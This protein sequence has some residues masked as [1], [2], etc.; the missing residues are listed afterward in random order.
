MTKLKNP[1]RPEAVEDLIQRLKKA[2]RRRRKGALPHRLWLALESL[3]DL[4]YVKKPFVRR[5]SKAKGMKARE[6]AELEP[7]KTREWL[8]SFMDHVSQELPAKTRGSRHLSALLVLLESEAEVYAEVCIALAAQRDPDDE[9]LRMFKPLRLR[10]SIDPGSR[11]ARHAEFDGENLDDAFENIQHLGWALRETLRELKIPFVH[12]GSELFR[13]NQV[14]SAHSAP[15]VAWCAVCWRTGHLAG[16]GMYFC[17]EHSSV[18]KRQQAYSL[19]HWRSA[20]QLAEDRSSYERVHFRA[21]NRLMPSGLAVGAVQDT[22]IRR[23]QLGQVAALESLEAYTIDVGE[24]VK[25]L[26]ETTEFLRDTTR[27]KPIDLSNARDV[28]T[29]LDPLAGRNRG[30]QELLHT[31][32]LKDQRILHER[33][34]YAE[35]W[36]RTAREKSMNPRG[37]PIRLT[38]KS[39]FERPTVVVP[40]RDEIPVYLER[41]ANRPRS[42]PS[43][44]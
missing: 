43:A 7:K 39:K 41:R 35:A 25:N 31:A 12:P 33:L 40:L 15:S 6:H 8:H 4:P 28:L 3:S 37:R 34:L 32:V 2:A 5:V 22:A 11:L 42:K 16:H 18:K 24:L 13:A 29:A 30:L 36:L 26:P 38:R 17:S 1:N 14:T 10:E 9:L 27:L 21:L 44:T 23:L 19:N 20:D